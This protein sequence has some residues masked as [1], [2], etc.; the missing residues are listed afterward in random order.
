MQKIFLT[1][2]GGAKCE[3]N[4]GGSSDIGGKL[5]G[6]WAWSCGMAYVCRSN[7]DITVIAF[8][9]MRSSADPSA[10]ILGRVCS[11]Q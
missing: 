2:Y 3:V 6:L 9:V 8:M 1:V 5:S 7:S 11:T 10:H 4:P